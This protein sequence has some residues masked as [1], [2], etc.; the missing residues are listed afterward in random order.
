MT[1]QVSSDG[2]EAPSRIIVASHDEKG[3]EASMPASDEEPVQD[4][5]EDEFPMDQG[6]VAWLQVLGSWIL[7]ANT[8]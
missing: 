4:V 5:K 7:F 3:L 8:W 2:S 1:V 6:L